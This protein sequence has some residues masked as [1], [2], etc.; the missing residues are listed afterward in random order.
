MVKKCK[1]NGNEK[2]GKCFSLVLKPKECVV[3][4]YILNEILEFV[5]WGKR[6][7]LL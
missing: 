6:G 7:V 5:G 2:L 4:L 1:E 3:N